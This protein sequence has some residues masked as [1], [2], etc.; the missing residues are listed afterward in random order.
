MR[1]L[2]RQ[3]RFS[4]GVVGAALLFIAGPAASTL[5]EL[6]GAPAS[7]TFLGTDANWDDRFGTHGTNGVV[8][9]IAV[10]G[11][12]VYVGGRFT[13]AGGVQANS[14]ARFDTNTNTWSALGSNVVGGGVGAS[15]STGTA[16]VT[17]IA[18]DSS[19]NVY[20]G[21]DFITADGGTARRLAMF[22]G[23]S[24]SALGNGL[25]DA[26]VLGG[27]VFPITALAARGTDI[28]VGGN[29]TEI[30]GNVPANYIARWNG[31]AWSALG[32]GIGGVPANPA[33]PPVAAIVV[34][35]AGDLFVGGNFTTAGGGGAANL[36]KFTVGSSTWSNLGSGTDG[37]V[38][39]LAVNGADLFIGGTFGTAGG[40]GVNRFARYNAGTFFNP[41]SGVNG[42]VFALAQVGSETYLGG[43]FT[44]GAGGSVSSPAIVA[45]NGSAF[46][47]VG[48]GLGG[49]SP[50]VFALGSNGSN[51]FFGGQFTIFGN[52]SANN[53]G[54]WNGS[55]F[56]TLGTGEA[57][58]L[59]GQVLDLVRS[60]AD[61]IATGTFRSAGG[62]A[63]NRIARWNGD[64]WSAMGSGLEGGGSVAGRSLAA[65]GND[66]YVGGSFTT[67]GGVA[68][69]GVAR[70]N[71]SSWSALGAGPGFNVSA[72]AVDGN[73]VYAGGG[74]GT[75]GV[76]VARWD[77]ASWTEIATG[78]GNGFPFAIQVLTVSGG[79]LYAGGEFSQLGNIP[80]VGVRNIASWN[81]S[82]WT[83]LATSM[84]DSG[85]AIPGISAI[86]VNGADVYAGGQFDL[87]NGVAANNVA[88]NTSG[89]WSALGAGVDGPVLASVQALAFTGSTLFVGG[90]FTTAGG[91]PAASIAK[92][93]GST[94]DALGSG[95]HSP[96][97]DF[98]PNAVE[99]EFP[100]QAMALV[101]GSLYVGGDLIIAGQEPSI[102]F[103]RYSFAELGPDLM[104][105]G[106]F[107]AGMSCWIAFASTN[108]VQDQAVIQHNSAANGQFEY[109]RQAPAPGSVNQAVVFQETGQAVGAF[110]PLEAQFDVGNSS[111][112]RKRI[113]VLVLA[114]NFSDLSVCTFWIP[115]N[116][117]LRTY[118]MHTHTTQAWANAAIYFYAASADFNGGTYILDN[119]T[120]RTNTGL[121]VQR[122]DCVDPVAPSAPGGSPGPDLLDNGNF[123]TPIN[124]ST[125]WFTFANLNWQQVGGVFEF[126]RWPPGAPQDPAGVVAQ[127]TDESISA[128]QIV[129][130]TF[131]LGNASSI[132]QRVTVLLGAGD[133]SDLHAC[134]FWL[135]AGQPL[136]DY[137]MRTYATIA[138]ATHLVS[139]YAATVANN[140]WMQLDNVTLRRTPGTAALGT[141]CIEPGGGGDTLAISGA[142]QV[143]TGAVP[144]GRGSDGSTLPPRTVADATTSPT[145]PIVATMDGDV[146]EWIATDGFTLRADADVAGTGLGWRAAGNVDETHTLQWS[147]AIDLRSIARARLSFWS[148]MTP[149]SS[150]AEV[151]ATVDGVNW[152]TI[153]AMASSD[154]WT[155]GDVD[156]GTFIGQIIEL[157]FIYKS[158][159]PGDSWK[160]DE[161]RIDKAAEPEPTPRS[162]PTP[163]G[164]R[165]RK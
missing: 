44:A 18:V 158:S 126:Y 99:V 161:V 26:D 115:P 52:A 58:G 112:V 121:S 86:V 19:G 42:T 71:G 124:A 84:S 11:S 35:G 24:W 133:F 3:V 77:G 144:L 23:S 37:V 64:S 105:N 101:G 127:G 17:A 81:G 27:A 80:P 96:L 72:V 122:T 113:S 142:P 12:N 131:Q 155:A 111:N 78:N 119:V 93:T 79:T 29:F 130:A 38:L 151:Q 83:P 53:V 114:H 149:G 82:I 36:A 98:A 48:G 157:R 153:A 107:S 5:R 50:V 76:K 7:T 134:T 60:G 73:I 1:N 139:I 4:L 123:S 33:N 135:P 41:G 6:A 62:V 28:Y 31:A 87:I 90:Q 25:D 66:V 56:V 146:S 39:A 140:P 165:L 143:M 117:P 13:M 30:N 103:G 89:T 21:G 162:T 10:S 40:V 63:V 129:T 69:N 109:W 85:F 54:R 49:T 34:D 120:L 138:H 106:T 94:W 55:S 88:K 159:S 136:S 91:N 145:A 47:S 137:T 100:I 116:S 43:N 67:A 160:I 59:D 92:W 104:C 9:A 102:F 2:H 15:A 132:R 45:W 148:W 51:P 125:D 57:Q 95:V 65:S 8:R 14:I 68:A 108:N 75:G 118:R 97:E 154:T 163:R 32:S 16:T 46:T 156:L 110:T 20:A 128:N 152:Q 22:N 61:V 150:V 147:R 70:W 74:G 141:E 164:P